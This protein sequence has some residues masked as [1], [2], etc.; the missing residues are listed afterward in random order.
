VILTDF[1][2]KFRG[3]GAKA[4]VGNFSKGVVRNFEMKSWV[5]SFCGEIGGFFADFDKDI[6]HLDSEENL[7]GGFFTRNEKNISAN[8]KFF[9]VSIG[10]INILGCLRLID[11]FD[12]IANDLSP[13]LSIYLQVLKFIKNKCLLLAPQSYTNTHRNYY[14]SLI[15]LLWMTSD[16]S[17][18]ATQLTLQ[19]PLFQYLLTDYFTHPTQPKNPNLSQES[20]IF[21]S[22][23][24]KPHK[25]SQFLRT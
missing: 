12:F 23:L 25:I 21:T 18:E 11:S 24:P 17:T 9:L 8:I 1:G 13:L 22:P 19:S 10:T 4:L 14:D 7:Q 20:K 6:Q 5:Q 16:V 15:F 2:Q 3:E